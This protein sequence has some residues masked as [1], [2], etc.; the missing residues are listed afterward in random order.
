MPRARWLQAVTDDE[1]EER[2]RALEME[3]AERRG[4]VKALRIAQTIVGIIVALLTTVMLVRG[5]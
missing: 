4:V 5:W 3:A 1:L 2:I